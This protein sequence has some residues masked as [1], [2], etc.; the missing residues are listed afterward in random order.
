MRKLLLTTA[1]VLA[2]TVSVFADGNMG[3][4]GLDG[5]MGSPGVVIAQVVAP[6]MK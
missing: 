4:P 3:S 1:F 6:L 5:N 2:L